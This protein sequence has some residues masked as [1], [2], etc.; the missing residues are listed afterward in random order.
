MTTDLQELLRRATE[1]EAAEP[2]VKAADPVLGEVLGAVLDRIEGLES[3]IKT[4]AREDVVDAVSFWGDEVK[5]AATAGL[6]CPKCKSSNVT[7]YENGTAECDDCGAYVEVPGGMAMKADDPFFAGAVEPVVEESKGFDFDDDGEDFLDEKAW[8]DLDA[9]ADA[10]L[11]V[12]SGSEGMV[13]LS[14]LE[15]LRGRRLALED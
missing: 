7:E 8:A 13:V 5:A 6:V 9:E 1:I 2:E 12:K 10:A 14:E 3:S 4:L 15:L 11:E